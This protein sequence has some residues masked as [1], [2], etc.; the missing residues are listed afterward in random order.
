MG[1]ATVSEINKKGFH[2]STDSIKDYGIP[3]GGM[4]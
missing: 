3:D 2:P 1:Q 4:L